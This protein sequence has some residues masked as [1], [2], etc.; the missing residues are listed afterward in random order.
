VNAPRIGGWFGA[1]SAL[2]CAVEGSVPHVRGKDD[3]WNTVAASAAA[4]GLIDYRLRALGRL[5]RRRGVG[6]LRRRDR[7]HV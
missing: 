6:A 2:L 3:P 7:C 5:P 4:L 1:Y